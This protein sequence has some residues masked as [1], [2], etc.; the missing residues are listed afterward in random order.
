MNVSRSRR[1]HLLVA[2]AAF[3]VLALIWAATV[4]M[5]S[6]Q[7]TPGVALDASW[8]SIV[9]A[10][11]T[12]P[13][14]AVADVFARLGGGIGSVLVTG[15][16][17]VLLLRRRGLRVGLIF[18]VVA[19][20]SEGNVNLMKAVDLR[21]RP[22]GGLWGGIGSFPSG[23]TA[24]AAV[25]AT[26]LGML[27]YR[28]AV[29]VGGFLF[30]VVMALTRTVLDAHWLTDTLGGAACGAALA[31]LVWSLVLPSRAFAPVADRSAPHAS[32]TRE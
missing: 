10:V 22:G 21:P 5:R 14:I 16:I 31:V 28:A 24:F 18:V 32:A 17:A 19:L 1:Q 20:L 3:A 15:A 27:F 8:A 7:S 9:H 30:V 2:G 23:H 4:A 11:R 12:R 13:M 6:V 25:L 29:W 26:T